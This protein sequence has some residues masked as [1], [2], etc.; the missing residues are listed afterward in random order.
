VSLVPFLRS[1]LLSPFPA[2]ADLDVSAQNVKKA[3]EADGGKCL[4]L[5]LDLMKAENCKEIVDKHIAEYGRLDILVNNAS[6]QI[7]SESV[8]EI[9]VSD[10]FMEIMQC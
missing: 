4:T 3:I 10:A 9:D 7:M 1:P 5:P 2:S 8:E 6:K